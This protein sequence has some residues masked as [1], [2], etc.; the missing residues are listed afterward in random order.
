MKRLYA[1]SISYIPLYVIDWELLDQK[2]IDDLEL[3]VS[4]IKEENEDMSYVQLEKLTKDYIDNHPNDCFRTI[5]YL[6]RAIKEMENPP[7]VIDINLFIKLFQYEGYAGLS[8]YDS[9]FV[10]QI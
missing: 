5:E 10:Y 1:N 6:N 7:K 3:I 8:G 2:I 9:H 4:K